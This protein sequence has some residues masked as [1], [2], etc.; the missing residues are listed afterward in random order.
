MR[1]QKSSLNQWSIITQKKI[2]SRNTA[3]QIIAGL[4]LWNWTLL[5]DVKRKTLEESKVTNSRKRAI[6]VA[7]RVTS[8]KIV[9]RET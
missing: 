8:Q 2:I 3:I 4:H 7:N 1:E 9:D 5:S 6:H